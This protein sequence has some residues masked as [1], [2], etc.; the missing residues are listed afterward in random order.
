[1]AH[2]L[3][4]V[5]PCLTGYLCGF[6]DVIIRAMRLALCLAHNIPDTLP[7]PLLTS[8]VSSIRPGQPSGRLHPWGTAQSSTQ[9]LSVGNA[10][11]GTAEPRHAGHTVFQGEPVLF[12]SQNIA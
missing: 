10:T 9:N 6:N 5:E 2:E 7:S 11:A 3:W 1:M 12:P 4:F 8:D